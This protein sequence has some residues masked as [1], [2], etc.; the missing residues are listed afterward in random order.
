M[1]T[2]EIFKQSDALFR[3][4]EYEKAGEFL[5]QKSK[6]AFECG[7]LDVALSVLNELTG[8]YRFSK[9]MDEAWASAEKLL[10]LVEYM[11]L[12]GTLEGAT[13][14]LNVAT[15]YKASD[16]QD[17]ALNLYEKVEAIYLDKQVTDDRI[18]GLYNNMCVTCL[19]LGQNMRAYKYGQK[20]LD[21]AKYCGE[22][23]PDR[24]ETMKY[25][26]AAA[27]QRLVKYG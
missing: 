15:V 8:W 9:R 5:E 23:R 24:L 21:Y 13:V 4:G 10:E 1:K 18:V 6:E 17:M 3:S 25:N 2:E 26:A 20:G 27:K 12:W 19:E 16:K 14:L 22:I 11:Q 7:Q